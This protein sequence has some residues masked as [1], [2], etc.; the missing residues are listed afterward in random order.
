MSQK[1]HE[2]YKIK[3]RIRIRN[4]GKKKQQHHQLK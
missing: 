2:E 1:E 3:E 4:S